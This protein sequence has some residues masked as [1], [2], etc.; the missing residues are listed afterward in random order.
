MRRPDVGYTAVSLLWAFHSG[1]QFV[2]RTAKTA[3]P[4]KVLLRG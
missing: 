1:V 2:Y 4:F 3:S